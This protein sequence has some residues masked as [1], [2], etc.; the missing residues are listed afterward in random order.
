MSDIGGSSAVI[1]NDFGDGT[2]TLGIGQS[3]L[4]SGVL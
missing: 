1:I 4:E 2:N 3:S